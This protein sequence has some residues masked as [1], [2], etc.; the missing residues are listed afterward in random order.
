MKEEDVTPLV[1]ARAGEMLR[2]ERETFDQRKQHEDRWFR[3]RLTMGYSSIA[4]LAGIMCLCM[5]IIF[6]AAKFPATVITSAGAALFVDVLGLLLGVWKIALNPNFMAT[7]TPVT[8]VSVP[9][10]ENESESKPPPEITA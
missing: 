4:L 3:L 10:P 5:Y 8:R 2:Q 6:N 9:A 1:V 7:L